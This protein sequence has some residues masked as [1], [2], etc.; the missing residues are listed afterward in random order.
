MLLSCQ[1]KLL[2]GDN[3][4]EKYINAAK[5]GFDSVEI[6]GSK[7]PPLETRVEEIKAA[8]NESG[9][10]PSTICGGYQ[11]WIADY[12]E[13]KRKNCLKQIKAMMPA[14]AEIGAQGVVVPAAYGMFSRVLPPFVPPRS[15]EDDTAVLIGSLYELGTEAA[16]HGTNVYLEPLNR[17]EDHMVNTVKDAVELVEAVGQKSVAVMLDL[18]HGS[19]EETDM[20]EVIETYAAHINHIHIA[21][22]NRLQP[23]K[24]HMDYAPIAAALSRIGYSGYCAMECGVKGEGLEPLA[25]VVRLFRNIT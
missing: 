24:G 15:K 7:Q 3:Y 4:T 8:V 1:D 20:P 12:D 13:D 19:I 9:I 11:G 22:T 14:M 18:F 2:P 21:D 25:Q 16:K 23:G 6:N 5:A 17:Y 10:S